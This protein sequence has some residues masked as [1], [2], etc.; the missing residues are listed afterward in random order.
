MCDQFEGSTEEL[1]C[2][3]SCSVVSLKVYNKIKNKNKKSIPVQRNFESFC[4][5]SHLLGQHYLQT[6]YRESAMVRVQALSLKC[7]GPLYRQ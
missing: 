6:E 1:E 4:I 2:F 3:A 7:G 5:L